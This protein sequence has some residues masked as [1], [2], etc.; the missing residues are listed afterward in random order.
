MTTDDKTELLWRYVSGELDAAGRDRVEAWLASDAELQ[1]QY[2]EISA[3]HTSL[4]AMEAEEPSLRFAKNVMDHLPATVKRAVVSK[5]VV[6]ASVLVLFLPVVLGFLTGTQATTS[7]GKPSA[8]VNRFNDLLLGSQAPDYGFV[9]A[10]TLAFITLFLL[11]RW[12]L[13]RRRR[14]N[15]A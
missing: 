9:M 2:R 11:D 5:R 3:L 8:L 7:G 13:A 12:W 15:A 6:W 1:R 4:R 10:I 14:A